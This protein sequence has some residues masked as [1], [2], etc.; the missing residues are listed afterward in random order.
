MNQFEACFTGDI[1][2]PFDTHSIYQEWVALKGAY[3]VNRWMLPLPL[4]AK[5]GYDHTGEEAWDVLREDSALDNTRN[6]MCIY[7]HIPFCSSKCGFCDSYSFA[8]SPEREIEKRLYVDHLC[9]ELELWSEMG[10]LG[11]RPVTSVHLGGGTP[12]FLGEECFSRLIRTCQE[13]Y[14][15]S[16]Q[17]E[18]ALEATTSTLTSAMIA[19]LH[20]IGFRRLHIGVQSLEDPVRKLIGRRQPAAQ[21]I[22]V[23]HKVIDLGWTVSVDLVCG[24]PG[25]RLA[26]LLDGIQALI[27]NGVNGFSL[28][29]LLIYTQ[30]RKWAAY[31][32]LIERDHLPNFFMFQAGAKLLETHGYKKNL[33]NHWAD[34][35]DQNIYFTFPMRREDLLAVGTIADGVFGDYHYRHLKYDP[36]LLQSSRT[37]PGLQGGLRRSEQESRLY[38]FVLAIQSGS[39]TASQAVILNRLVGP[40]GQ[41]LVERWITH[42]LVEKD[43]QGCL[44]LTAN[45]S[46]FAGNMINEMTE[47]MAI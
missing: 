5:R 12:T 8:L 38:P 17:T 41:P 32:N 21:V 33:F 16:K 11:S 28:Y 2:W 7:L 27:D 45:G 4:W 23:I 35:K 20:E 15:Y 1:S 43:A 40:Q 6:A 3:D 46:W 26:G 36:Y 22:A 47:S 44:N 29:E 31:H 9:A 18:W 39:I 25:Q 10:N 13:H 14:A 34:A 24:L 19:F 37:N 30:N 42:A